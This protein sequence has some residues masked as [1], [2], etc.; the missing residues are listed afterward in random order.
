MRCSSI[1]LLL[2]LALALAPVEAG[3]QGRKQRIDQLN[4]EITELKQ[5]ID[6]ELFGLFED[7]VQA[8]VYRSRISNLQ[9]QWQAL[10]AELGTKPKLSTPRP[11]P[12]DG[13]RIEE[14]AASDASSL[15]MALAT[16][17]CKK[18]KDCRV[19]VRVS[20][21]KDLVKKGVGF[22]ISAEIQNKGGTRRVAV[23]A[24]SLTVSQPLMVVDLPLD[25]SYLRKDQYQVTLKVM[26]D[27]R[28]KSKSV[29]F[30]LL[31]VY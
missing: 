2:L 18:S 23:P 5:R 29:E 3:A 28:Y 22:E 4:Q 1:S 15:E 30:E 12:V 6:R 7:Q 10:F 19:W 20:F 17:S 11:A 13:F 25:R 26:C 24:K 14:L 31:G 8:A 9:R 16:S 27:G 21:G